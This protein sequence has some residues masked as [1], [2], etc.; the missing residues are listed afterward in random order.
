MGLGPSVLLLGG[1]GALGRGGWEPQRRGY[2]G[3]GSSTRA[4][5]FVLPCPFLTLE[6][7]AAPPAYGDWVP[8]S[9]SR[10]WKTGSQGRPPCRL[11]GWVTHAQVGPGHSWVGPSASGGMS[12]SSLSPVFPEPSSLGGR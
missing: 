3:P 9:L 12:S 11:S 10:R 4:W 2:L 1:E 5:E 7:S 8:W 6:V